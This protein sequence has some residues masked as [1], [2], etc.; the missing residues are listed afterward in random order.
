MQDLHETI[1]RALTV[2]PFMRILS[3]GVLFCPLNGGSPAQ[4][5]RGGERS[6]PIRRMFIMPYD[7]ENQSR[8][9]DFISIARR[10]IRNPRG[11]RPRQTEPSG[12]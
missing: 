12:P 6:E 7:T 1:T 4:P 3:R 11:R 5:D 10:A 2:E 8:N 9:A